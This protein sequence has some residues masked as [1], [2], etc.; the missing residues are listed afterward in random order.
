MGLVRSV[1]EYFARSYL[2]KLTL[3]MMFTAIS[4]LALVFAVLAWGMGVEPRLTGAHSWLPGNAVAIG[5]LASLACAFALL[6][7]A[8][9][10][11]ALVAPLFGVA[12]AV[13]AM[14]GVW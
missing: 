9:L 14:E 2:R 12:G 1:R 6:L 10:A 7:S 3:A 8:W 13:R 4:T 11:R 5:A